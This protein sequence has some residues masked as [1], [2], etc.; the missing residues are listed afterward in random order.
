MAMP[1]TFPCMGY[2]CNMGGN[3]VLLWMYTLLSLMWDT[4]GQS[5][6]WDYTYYRALDYEGKYI[7]GWRYNETDIEF[8]LTAQTQGYI[9]FGLSKTGEMY[10]ADLVIGWMSEGQM[11]LGV[12]R[13]VLLSNRCKIFRIRKKSKMSHQPNTAT[14]GL[15]LL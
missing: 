6:S 12:G 11:Y 3:M 14:S 5:T 7:L 10:P 4:D 13:I 8:E 15:F 1:L 9:G 2:H